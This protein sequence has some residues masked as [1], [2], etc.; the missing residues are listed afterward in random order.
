MPEESADSGEVKAD[1]VDGQANTEDGRLPHWM[2]PLAGLG[3]V[4]G[5][6]WKQQ[7]EEAFQRADERSWQRLRRAGRIGRRKRNDRFARR[8]AR[9]EAVSGLPLQRAEQHEY[10]E[11]LGRQTSTQHDSS[12]R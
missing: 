12:G 9:F 8:F 4:A 10:N 11:A 5:Q 7:V 3:L 1:V 2:A 6:G